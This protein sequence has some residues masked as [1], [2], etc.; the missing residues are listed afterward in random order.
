MMLKL[1]VS[2]SLNVIR[3]RSSPSDELYSVKNSEIL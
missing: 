3:M 2:D 1:L